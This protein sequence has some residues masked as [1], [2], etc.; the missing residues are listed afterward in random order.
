MNGVVRAAK[1]VIAERGTPRSDSMY[2]GSD[3]ALNQVKH[4]FV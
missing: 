4:G 3:G 1:D 2:C